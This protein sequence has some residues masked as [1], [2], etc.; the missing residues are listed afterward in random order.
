M[1]QVVGASQAAV[2]GPEFVV[3]RIHMLQPNCEEGQ[4]KKLLVSD[5]ALL[6][7]PNP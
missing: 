6:T 4:Q 2:W 7:V 3:L 5:G 1:I